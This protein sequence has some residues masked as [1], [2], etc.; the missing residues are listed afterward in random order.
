MM[1]AW[2][3]TKWI[4]FVG[5]GLYFGLF[6]IPKIYP[7]VGATP[8][9]LLLTFS[10]MLVVPLL[11]LLA[12]WGTVALIASKVRKV[13][14]GPKSQ[15]AGHTAF[16]G[17]SMFVAFVALGSMLP[18]QLPSGSH[19]RAFDREAWL[20]PASTAFTPREAT[21]RQ[22]MLA[23]AIAQLPN[24]SRADLEAMLGPSMDSNYFKG[25]GRDLIYVTGPERDSFFGIDSEWLLIWVDDKGTYERHAVVTD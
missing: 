12:I 5:F 6:L 2:S 4:N 22:K 25:T 24:K 10:F 7:G 23:N 9:A 19:D 3:R 17:I 15:A 1:D 18:A 16:A 20:D 11:A 8:F 21:P 13:P 14:I